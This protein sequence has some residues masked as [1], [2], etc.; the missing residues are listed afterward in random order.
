ML[1]YT[2]KP[3]QEVKMPEKS[4]KLLKK[5]FL[6]LALAGLFNYLFAHLAYLNM[7]TDTGVVYEYVTLYLS[8][9]LNFIAPVAVSFIALYAYAAH[10]RKKAVLYS[11]AL[12]SAR[13]A[14]YLPYYYIIYIFNY[15]Y[16]SIESI[17]L[18]LLSSL[19]VSIFTALLALL[20]IWLW[21]LFAKKQI[22]ES[23]SSL[24]EYL[25]GAITER[26]SPADFT[27]GA[28]LAFL[29]ASVCS[30]V[31]LLIP[32]IIDTVSF[33]ISYRQDYLPIEIITMLVNYVLLFILLVAS[34]LLAST[35][36]KLLITKT[37][38]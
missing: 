21:C 15:G 22:A 29:I 23:C 37:E 28:N 2:S 6:I 38:E 8:K 17:L 36:K 27:G 7:N 11:I 25:H 19:G 32:E 24:E 34:Y 10:G 31:C 14:Y 3:A 30:F 16:D 18:S 33:F 20:P 5:S 1:K 26:Q 4:N 13:I 12:S 35:V 9:I